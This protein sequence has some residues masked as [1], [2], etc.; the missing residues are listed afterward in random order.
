MP[1]L[2][3]LGVQAAEAPTDLGVPRPRT[4]QDGL[5]AVLRYP[6]LPVL[7]ASVMIED[8]VCKQPLTQSCSMAVL[9]GTVGALLAGGLWVDSP[10]IKWPLLISGVAGAIM[11]STRSQAE[12]DS[13]LTF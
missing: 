13:A 1:M 11:F 5:N 9:G 8:T 3:G 4:W 2:R 10:W 12:I 7:L 6:A